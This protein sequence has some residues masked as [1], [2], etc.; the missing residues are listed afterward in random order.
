MVFLVPLSSLLL[1]GSYGYNF[2][3]LPVNIVAFAR[4]GNVLSV[5]PSKEGHKINN[6]S[7]STNGKTE[8]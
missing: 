2:C 1:A 6:L 3:C 4:A 8:A 5:L 7:K